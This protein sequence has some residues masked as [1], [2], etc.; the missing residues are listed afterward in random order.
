MYPAGTQVA[1]LS[2][3]EAHIHTTT[4]RA[5]LVLLDDGHCLPSVLLNEIP[6]AVPLKFLF[7]VSSKPFR[8]SNPIR[9][10]EAAL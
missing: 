3:G 2:D 1:I 9:E 8:P 4:T 6:V 7:P 10:S 5:D